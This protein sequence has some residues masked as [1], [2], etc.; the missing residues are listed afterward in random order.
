MWMLDFS[1]TCSEQQW[2]Q[3]WQQ[4]LQSLFVS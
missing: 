1:V 4:Q 2:D 3:L